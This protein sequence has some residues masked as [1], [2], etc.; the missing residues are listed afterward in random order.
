MNP[1]EFQLS[2]R[3]ASDALDNVRHEFHKILCASKVASDPQKEGLV[4]NVQTAFNSYL[5]KTTQTYD[6]S[7]CVQVRACL[8]KRSSAG[9]AVKLMLRD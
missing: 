6:I 2:F 3:S 7:A 9:F 4:N 8:P 5:R 1:V